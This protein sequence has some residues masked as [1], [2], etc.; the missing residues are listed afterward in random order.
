MDRNNSTRHP[1]LGI[2]VQVFA[3]Q[4]SSLL[5]HLCR[6]GK[7][8]SNFIYA[9][10]IAVHCEA[11][12]SLNTTG[13]QMDARPEM[14][15]IMKMVIGMLTTIFNRFFSGQHP[16]FDTVVIN[17]LIIRRASSRPECRR[18]PVAGEALDLTLIS[19]WSIECSIAPIV[20][21]S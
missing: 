9:L 10:L 21:E 1:N 14:N 15:R 3:L 18:V 11:F 8:D 13:I 7:A 19:Q 5:F 12:S 2:V 20:S 17:S 4:P 16:M 6:R